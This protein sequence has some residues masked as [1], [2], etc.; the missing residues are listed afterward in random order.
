MSKLRISSS[1][2]IRSGASTQKIM[3]DVLIALIPC[4][5]ASVLVFGTGSLLIIAVSVAASVLS[6]YI[7]RRVM[8]RPNSISDLSAAVTG[9]LYAL[10]LPVGTPVYVVVLGAVFAVVV[11]KQLFGGLGCNIVNPALAGR[12]FMLISFTA[13]F[14]DC[15]PVA[16]D[17]VSGATPLAGSY[18]AGTLSYW[19]LAVGAYG[20]AIGETCKIAIL[21]GLVYLLVRRI[22][23]IRIP[24]VMLAS[25][26]LMSLC[27]GRDPLFDLLTGGIMFGAVFMAT[28]YATSPLSAWGQVIYAALCGIITVLIRQFG[29]YPEGTMFAIL[30]MNIATPLI[31]KLIR[32]RVFG[33]VK[34]K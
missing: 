25:A 27:L 26:A 15:A 6:E 21:I 30:L 31:D 2:H 16:S 28:D 22:I 32:P 18:A 9:V 4:G 23:S 12:A 10:T 33:E 19:Q 13:Q 7:S 11:A 20:G 24:A 5:I 3:A 1:P 8:K 14:A 29:A 17:A 34:A